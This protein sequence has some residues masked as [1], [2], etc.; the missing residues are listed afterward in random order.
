MY[1]TVK[2]P[3]GMRKPALGSSIDWGHPLARGLA[4]SFAF[5]E[6]A[7]MIVADGVL[8]R[9][10]TLAGTV[11][12]VPGGVQFDGTNGNGQ[13][14]ATNAL[15][16]PR[17]TQVTWVCGAAIHVDNVNAPLVF[18]EQSF[19]IY[20]TTSAGKKCGPWGQNAANMPAVTPG[21]YVDHAVVW[22]DNVDTCWY[23]RNGVIYSTTTSVTTN[24]HPDAHPLQLAARTGSSQYLSSTIDYLH[25]YQGR[26]LSAA[27]VAWLYT[28]PYAMIQA[29][30]MPVFYSIPAGG[31]SIA[32]I[33]AY[34]ARMRA[35]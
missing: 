1:F 9:A 11:A 35:A 32:A 8:P 29:P 2:Q 27:E 30:E 33:S 28:E 16:D 13:M 5:N 23:Y 3:W 18:R 7:G 14:T 31:S 6:R 19:Y 12:W 22:D 10:A 17:N 21:Q 4:A 20:P 34:Y 26:A 25:M 24:S 15:C